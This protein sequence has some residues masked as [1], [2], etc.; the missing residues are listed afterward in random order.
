MRESSVPPRSPVGIHRLRLLRRRP[1]R[2]GREPRAR[3]IIPGRRVTR[4]GTVAPQHEPV[5]REQRGV[6]IDRDPAHV[7]RDAEGVVV[8]EVGRD[9]EAGRLRVEQGQVGVADGRRGS[10]G[11]L[12][13]AVCAADARGGGEGDVLLEPD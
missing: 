11:H 4:R 2:P 8:G 3:A 12:G 10:V 7:E 9:D 13:A 1:V 5:C 6:E